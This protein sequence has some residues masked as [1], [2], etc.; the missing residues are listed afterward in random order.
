MQDSYIPT[1]EHLLAYYTWYA[2]VGIQDEVEIDSRQPDL[3]G[4]FRV[5]DGFGVG[6]SGFPG[7][8]Y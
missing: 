3:Q 7:K 2:V 5:V 1:W 6:G 8:G 4:G